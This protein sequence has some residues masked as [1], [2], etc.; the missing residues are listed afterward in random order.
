MQSRILWWALA[1]G[2]IVLASAP[3]ASFLWW[4]SFPHVHCE[5]KTMREFPSP[6]GRQVALVIREACGGATNPFVTS[7]AI[8]DA[9]EDFRFDGTD[10][11]LFAVKSEIAMEIVWDGNS[12]LTIAYMRSELIYRQ[13]VVWRTMPISYREKR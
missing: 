12:A 11:R 4:L 8:K 2:F 10:D 7:V 9:G 5:Y 3:I 13:L 6:N 1:I